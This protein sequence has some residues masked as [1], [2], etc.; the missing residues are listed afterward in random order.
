MLF[1][2]VFIL[3]FLNFCKNPS[4]DMKFKIIF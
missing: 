4:F 2:P 1:V 3:F